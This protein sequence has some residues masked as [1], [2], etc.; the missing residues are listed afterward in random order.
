M[1]QEPGEQGH[2]VCAGVGVTPQ[3][4]LGS[5]CRGGPRGEELG[6]TISGSPADYVRQVSFFI[7]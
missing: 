2:S 5:H 1:G 3:R 4:L 7:R 6:G